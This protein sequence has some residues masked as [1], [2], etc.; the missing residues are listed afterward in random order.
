MPQFDDAPY[1]QL[2][3]PARGDIQG[4]IK[5]VSEA[6]AENQTKFSTQEDLHQ[7]GSWASKVRSV[8]ASAAVTLADTDPIFI[9][10]DPNG[11]DRDVNCPAKSDDNHGYFIHHTGS[12][13]TL[14]VKR[15]GGASIG[16]LATGE[17]KYIKPSTINDFSMLT[18]GSGGAD[19]GQ[20]FALS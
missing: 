11:A 4:V 6:L 5:D 9:E 2:T 16:T 12:A 17:I 8:T 3:T 14:T 19:V 15:S 13:N 20:I 10:I 7:Y 18:S 1:T